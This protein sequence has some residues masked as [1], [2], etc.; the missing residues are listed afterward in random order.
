MWGTVTGRAEG[1]RD[2]EAEKVQKRKGTMKS[3]THK[4]EEEWKTIRLGSVQFGPLRG[5][6]AVSHA[7]QVV[8]ARASSSRQ[9]GE[10]NGRK[11]GRR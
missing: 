7:S 5:G 1:P 4:R 9:Q 11:R 3:T 6:P 10:R 8:G 2:V